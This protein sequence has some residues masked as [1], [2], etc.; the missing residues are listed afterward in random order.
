M[1]IGIIS[2][3]HDNMNMLKK[4]VDVFNERRV[5]LV[6]HAG[7]YIAP[8][9]ARELRRLNCKLVGVF[10]NNDGDKLML[11]K[12]FEGFGQLHD[13]VHQIELEGKMIAITHY[14]ALAE[15]LAARGAYDVV[16]YGHTHKVDIRESK[17]MVINPG[18]CGGWLEGRSTIAMLDLP[19]MRA[20]LV[21]L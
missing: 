6:L 17:P 7:D 8:F 21:S 15:T 16:V 19:A 9:T 4:A 5:G 18:E 13:G 1:L 11:S 12:Q 10:G 14:P 2:D 20:E 3:S